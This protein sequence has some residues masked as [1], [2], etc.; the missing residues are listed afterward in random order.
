MQLHASIQIEAI[1][2]LAFMESNNVHVTSK[3]SNELELGG[4]LFTK[5]HKIHKYKHSWIAEHI[6]WQS[7][8]L[9]RL[10]LIMCTLMFYHVCSVNRSLTKYKIVLQ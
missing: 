5:W 9:L 6:V 10:Y 3:L 7:V 2:L 4:H 1:S 8:D